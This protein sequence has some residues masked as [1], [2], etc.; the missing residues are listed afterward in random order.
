MSRDGDREEQIT[1][2]EDTIMEEQDDHRRTDHERQPAQAGPLPLLCQVP[3]P[4][5][6]PHPSQNLISMYGLDELAKSV[7]RKDA[8][9]GEKINKLR[10]SYEGKVKVLGLP[11]RNKPID[12]PGELLGLMEWPEEGWYDQRVHGFELERALEGP[13]MAKLDR[14]LIMQPGRLPAPEHEHWKNVLG[15]DDASTSAA[16]VKTP[17]QAPSKNAAQNVMQRTQATSMRASAP[18][19]PRGG[20]L[21][22]DRAGKKRRYDDASYEGYADGYQ[23]EDGYST[24]GLDGERRNSSGKKR[25]R[26]RLRCALTAP[27]GLLLLLLLRMLNADKRLI[28]GVFGAR[29]VWIRGLKRKPIRQLVRHGGRQDLLN[30]NQ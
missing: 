3:H 13:V 1:E 18:A 9:T 20:G 15:L 11:G 23:E 12:R 22:P 16:G 27:S 29:L 25:R 7:A 26:V 14:A 4:Q 2:Q 10:K 17:L 24:S 28:I 5:C 21:R 6:A 8:V 30:C 19:S